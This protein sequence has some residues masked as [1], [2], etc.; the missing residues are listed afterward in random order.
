MNNTHLQGLHLP[1]QQALDVPCDFLHQLL[2]FVLLD[3]KQISV[4]L[5]DLEG[6]RS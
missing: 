6:S 1:V 5:I 2:W 3:L 4:V